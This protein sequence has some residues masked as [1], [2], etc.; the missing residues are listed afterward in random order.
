MSPAGELERLDGAL[1]KLYAAALEDGLWPSALSALGDACG[2]I[3]GHLLVLGAG[4]AP[5]ESFMG[6]RFPEVN[7]EY[8]EHYSRIDPRLRL[9]VALPDD[10]I[11]SC[12]RHFDADFVRRDPFYNE[13]L[14]PHRFRY[15]AGCRL[16]RVD[17]A[18]AIFGMHRA[19]RHGAFADEDVRLLARLIPHLRCA[20]GIR[21]R[22]RSAERRSA[23]D[24]AAL[25]QLA[26]AVI[27]VDG[28]G[29]VRTANDAAARLLAG[30]DG[31]V[32]RLGRLGAVDPA[33]EMRLLKL[34]AEAAGAARCRGGGGG[35]IALRR[36]RGGAHAVLVAP[37][38]PQHAMA[39]G[40]PLAL[41]LAT[42]PAEAP[43]TLGRTLIEL[44]GFSQAEACLA[45]LLGRGLTLREAAA[46]RA[47]GIET[48]R[49]Q[50]RSLLHKA[51]LHRQADLVRL[52]GRLPE[53]RVGSTG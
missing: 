9:V 3:G 29:L 4:G 33:D 14:L 20:V 27:V 6:S 32:A 26:T 8:V 18:T 44:Y 37:L 21:Q 25:N 50:L 1:G 43:R 31:L 13:F 10:Q 12:H 15:V 42:D 30:G 49:S 17:G 28:H 39:A 2:S 40:A 51:G 35:A 38:G 11:F 24:A 41:V 22:L 19:E 36:Q 5:P 16:S 53:V 23:A 48:V 7:H 46:E 52:L 47:V 34:V 45:V